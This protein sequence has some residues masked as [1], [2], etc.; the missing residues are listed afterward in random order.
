MRKRKRKSGVPRG[1]GRGSGGGGGK[2]RETVEYLEV[3]GEVEEWR[4]RRE[5]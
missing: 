1:R 2:Y 4:G 3:E 5:R